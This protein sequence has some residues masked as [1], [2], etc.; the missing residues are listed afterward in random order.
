MQDVSESTTRAVE[1]AEQRPAEA[2]AKV[3]KHD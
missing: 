2:A 1:L 3:N